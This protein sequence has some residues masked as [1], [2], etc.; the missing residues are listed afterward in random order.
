MIINQVREILN[1]QKSLSITELAE[2]LNISAGAALDLSL[3]VGASLV[4]QTVYIGEPPVTEMVKLR[5][6]L[7][8]KSD[9]VSEQ[10]RVIRHL[11]HEV[12]VCERRASFLTSASEEERNP[13]PI[14]LK[15]STSREATVLLLA[16]DWHVGETVEPEVV[17]DLNQYDPSIAKERS[18]RYFQNA[19]NLIKKED[20]AVPV[21]HI[22]L[23]LGGDLITGYIHEELEE[24]NSMSPVQE[25]LFCQGLITAGLNFLQD[26]LQ[27]DSFQVVCSY[28]NHGRTTKKIRFNTG[29]KNSYEWMM[30]QFLK[31]D[32]PNLTWSITEGYFTYLKV[33]DQV[34]RFHH[35]DR[36]KWNGGVGG[37]TIP[38]NRFIARVN[39][40]RV[41]N[42]DV[43]GHFH[44]LG[45]GGN[46][47]TNG[48][49]IGPSAYSVHTGCTSERPQQGFLVIDSEHGF[50]T[51][52]PIVVG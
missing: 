27:F 46:H 29:A 8:K 50:S 13:D 49:L 2:Q 16:S 40:Q 28:G 14:A 42:L 3:E 1:E 10:N 51:F 9:K 15:Q 17:N 19:L 12:E 7:D 34:L 41:A 39:T 5:R 36:V 44:T 47:L 45:Y 38:L 24:S 32:H 30:Y 33:Y 6:Q 22:V 31:K 48:S 25:V 4:D 21:K 20:H 35:G 37:I 52:S 18:E 43:L 11:N 26:N 23:W